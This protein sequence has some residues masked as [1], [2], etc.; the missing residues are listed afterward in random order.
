MKV[1]LTIVDYLE[2]AELVYGDRTVVVDEPDQPATAWEDLTGARMGALARAQAAGLD[3]LGVGIGERV[4]VVSHNSARLLTAFWGVSAYGRILVPINFR[5]NVR[6]GRVHRR[7][8]RRVGAAR[9]SR[10]RRLVGRRRRRATG[11]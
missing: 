1:P 7:A 5:L 4:A 8:L 6:R 3:H 2:R 10:A 9:R 11:S